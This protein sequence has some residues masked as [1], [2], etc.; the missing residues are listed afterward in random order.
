MFSFGIACLLGC[1]SVSLVIGI[2]GLC[3]SKD[4]GGVVA[5]IFGIMLVVMA[6]GG[7]VAYIQMCGLADGTLRWELVDG[8]DGSRAWEIRTVKQQ[9][10]A[11]P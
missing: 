8:P 4:G 10:R 5:F 7:F 2:T 6:F 1:L 9:D 3:M 11:S